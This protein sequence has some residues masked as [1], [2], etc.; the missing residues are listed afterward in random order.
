MTRQEEALALFLQLSEAEQEA[1]L[2]RLRAF[3]AE[4]EAQA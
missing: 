3:V 4:S 2:E 1:Y